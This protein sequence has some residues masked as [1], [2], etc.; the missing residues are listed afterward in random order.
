MTGLVL[1]R[2]RR[3]A[4]L[5]GPDGDRDRDVEPRRARPAEP[6]TREP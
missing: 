1:G 4:D 5:G 3:E 2:E 6:A